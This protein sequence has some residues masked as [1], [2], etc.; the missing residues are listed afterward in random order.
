MTQLT[1]AQ[2]IA[3][4]DGEASPEIVIQVEQSGFYQERLKQLAETQEAL[5]DRLY[6]FDCPSSQELGDFHLDYL[7]SREK[8]KIRKHLAS[9]PN[10]TA[11]LEQLRAFQGTSP[12]L[13]E[14]GRILIAR[15]ISNIDSVDYF[16]QPDLAPAWETRGR[17]KSPLIFQA[18]EFQIV[19]LPDLETKQPARYTLTGLVVGQTTSGGEVDLL[20]S[21]RCA[22]SAV[23][24]DLGNFAFEH[25]EPG[26]YQMIVG[27]ESVEIHTP[28]FIV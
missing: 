27:C 19:I 23:I 9:C 12:G 5:Q 11:E 28:S 6:R 26:E 16:S 22:A 1:D 24:D 15:L 20:T 25:V 13:I 7:T 18:D 14:L 17:E 4:L 2:L 3:Y 8:A 10:C 21:E